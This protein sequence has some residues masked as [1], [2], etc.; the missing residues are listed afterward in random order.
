MLVQAVGSSIQITYQT[1]AATF[2][3]DQLM[4]ALKEREYVATLAQATDKRNPNA[5]PIPIPAFSKENV[6]IFFYSDQKMFVVQILNTLD[7]TS[8]LEDLKPILVKLNMT[9]SVIAVITFTCRTAILS[10]KKDPQKNLTGLINSKFLDGI[11]SQVNQNLKVGSI[12]FIT[13]MQEGQDQSLE[14]LLEPLDADPK[15]EHY[16]FVM[17]YKTSDMKK[18]NDFIGKF[19]QDMISSIVEQVER[20][21]V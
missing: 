9:E 12:R 17:V 16:S 4:R 11:N 2:T 15:K 19:G 13:E 20:A 10:S 3:P 21:N 18:F 7:L 5:P 8:L 1:K 14:L 6:N